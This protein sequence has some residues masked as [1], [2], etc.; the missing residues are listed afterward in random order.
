MLLLHETVSEHGTIQR[1][2]PK[3]LWT[4]SATRIDLYRRIRI[5][6]DYIHANLAEPFSLGDAASTV[7]LSKPAVQAV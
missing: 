3:L 4:R 7:S 6:Q 1:Q 5:V 2:I